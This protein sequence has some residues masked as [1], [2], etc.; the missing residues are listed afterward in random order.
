[1]VLQVKRDITKDLGR[2]QDTAGSTCKRVEN[3][4]ESV[5]KGFTNIAETTRLQWETIGDKLTTEM[6]RES[7]V[8]PIMDQV[9]R[10]V[11]NKLHTQHSRKNPGKIYRTH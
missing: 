6:L 3:L 8:M 2:L 10:Y 5:D 4:Q 9:Q 7:I 1:M 11:D